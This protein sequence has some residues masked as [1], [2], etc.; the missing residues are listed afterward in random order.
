MTSRYGLEMTTVIK[1]GQ[2]LHQ[3]YV[4]AT[5][6]SGMITLFLKVSS[7]R[8]DD[9]SVFIN[10]VQTNKKSACIRSRPPLVDPRYVDKTLNSTFL[11]RRFSRE[12]YFR[13]GSLWCHGRSVCLLDRNILGRCIPV[14]PAEESCE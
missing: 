10:T 5:A 3:E 9:C 13:Q 4:V 12:R 7:M 2:G 1:C 11:L 14:Q 8:L 6:G